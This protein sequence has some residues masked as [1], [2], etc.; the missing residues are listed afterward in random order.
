MYGFQK[1]KR[2]FCSVVIEFSFGQ[3]YAFLHSWPQYHFKIQ[4]AQVQMF[5]SQ[6]HK[7]EK[8]KEHLPVRPLL[9]YLHWLGFFLLDRVHCCAQLALM[10][11]QHASERINIWLTSPDSLQQSTLDHALILHGHQ[12][13]SP[14]LL[15]QNVTLQEKEVGRKESYSLCMLAS[16]VSPNV[17]I[18]NSY[19]SRS[20][21]ISQ[22]PTS[23]DP[24]SPDLERKRVDLGH[25]T[26]YPSSICRDYAPKETAFTVHLI[27]YFSMKK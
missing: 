15:S 27:F 2:K 20:D 8:I 13:G 7:L 14:M 24:T 22:D 5:A 26:F 18:Y 3:V 12:R 1:K 16:P 11:F 25:S 21:L 10:S 19:L 6:A 4:S 9:L 17:H 23:A